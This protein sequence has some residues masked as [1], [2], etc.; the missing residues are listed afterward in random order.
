MISDALLFFL[1]K[2]L[3]QLLY[4]G[5]SGSGHDNVLH[6]R[7]FKLGRLVVD[8]DVFG[9]LLAFFTLLLHDQP[10]PH[11]VL[12][13]LLAACHVVAILQHVAEDLLLVLNICNLQLH[14]LLL[15]VGHFEFECTY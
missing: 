14:I 10:V 1:P 11:S 12:V 6:V 3:L 9:Q 15:M 7:D 5:T 13:P 8:R 2:H 4:K